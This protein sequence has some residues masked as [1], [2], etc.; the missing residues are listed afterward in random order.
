MLC[1]LPFTMKGQVGI[2]TTT[3]HASSVLDIE[4][5]N[6]GVLLPRISLDSTLDI[7]T[8]SNPETSLLIYNTSTVNDVSAGFYFWEN[9]KWNKLNADEKIFGEIYKNSSSASQALSSN[10]PIDFGS[11]VVSEGVVSNS[12]NFQITTSG[13]YRVTYS[14]SIL[15]TAGNPINLGFYLSKG[16]DASDTVDGSFVH[17]QLDEF[18]N[19]S[20]HM[21]KIIHLSVNDKIYLFPNITNNNVVIKPDAATMNIELIKAD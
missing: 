10:T 1:C 16:F 14:V 9:S 13:Y 11:T 6:S 2:G 19:I 4:S 8:I 17:T 15:K 20:F 12:N 21:N 3:P 7:A 18:R 5:S